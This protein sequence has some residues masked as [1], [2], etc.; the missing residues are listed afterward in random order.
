MSRPAVQRL[1]QRPLRS[2]VSS[3]AITTTQ[4]RTMMQNAARSLPDKENSF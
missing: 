1:L 4:H 2:F 3:S